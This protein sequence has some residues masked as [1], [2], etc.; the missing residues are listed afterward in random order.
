MAWREIHS[1]LKPH[2]VLAR[3]RE[4]TVPWESL[5]DLRRPALSYGWYVVES[6]TGPR[7]FAAHINGLRFRLIPLGIK[8]FKGVSWTAPVGVLDGHVIN[9]SSGSRIETR[10]RYF[11][12]YLLMPAMGFLV[13]LMVFVP[14]VALNATAAN[15]TPLDRWMPWLAGVVLGLLEVAMCVT[16]L[17]GVRS[18]R[19]ASMQFVERLFLEAGLS[20]RIR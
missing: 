3:I 9:Q 16:I 7:L 19:R 14:W 6:L 2:D 20:P 13:L 10:Y 18:Q 5:V 12:P 17:A 11:L 4:A 1:S 8:P 15:L